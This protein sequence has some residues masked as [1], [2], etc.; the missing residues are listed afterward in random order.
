MGIVFIGL[1][2]LLFPLLRARKRRLNG[3][4]WKELI[5]ELVEGIERCD[6][7]S[8]SCFRLALRTLECS[9]SIKL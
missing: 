5:A 3:W 1:A 6:R 8:Y 4:N 9:K 2:V 7:A